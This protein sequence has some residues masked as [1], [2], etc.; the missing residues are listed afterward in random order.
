MEDN[1][2]RKRI[3]RLSQGR[4][5]DPVPKVVL[6]CSELTMN[7]IW[8]HEKTGSFSVKSTNGVTLN[9]AVY[10]SSPYVIIKNSVISGT[11]VSV[12]F[13]LT[14]TIFYPGDLLTGEFVIVLNRFET[15]LP[16]KFSFSK[17]K[18]S[19]K[20]RDICNMKDF[21]ML[22][23]DDIQSAMNLFYRSDF[24]E[25]ME[26]ADTNL[27]LIYRGYK[28][29]IP[30]QIN[31][32]NF[33]SD[34]GLKDPVRITAGCREKKFIGMEVDTAGSITLLKNT[35]GYLSVKIS[36]DSSFIEL[37]KTHIR[38]ND[39]L[40]RECHIGFVIKRDALHCGL[41]YGTIT[42]T[43]DR[44]KFDFLIT[45]SPDTEKEMDRRR[46]NLAAGYLI[47]GAC[48]S[49]ISMRLGISSPV[50]FLRDLRDAITAVTAK[51]RDEA[52]LENGFLSYKPSHWYALFNVYGLIMANE[53]RDALSAIEILR[54]SI[55]DRKSP[56]WAFLLYLLILMGIDKDDTEKLTVEIEKIFQ[57]S[58]EDP[59]LFLILLSVRNEYRA[60]KSLKLK[61]IRQWVM[62]GY[63]SPFF[64]LEA[65]LVA[66]DNPNLL[67][68]INDPF[69]R[70]ILHF[71]YKKKVFSDSI[72]KRIID[73]MASDPAFRPDTL[74]ILINTYNEKNSDELLTEIVRYMIRGKRKEPLDARW[75]LLAIEKNLPVAGIYEFYMECLPDDSS[76]ALPE[77]VLMYFRYPGTLSYEKQAFLYSSVVANKNENGKIYEEYRRDSD[78]FAISSAMEHT[79]NE[80]TLILYHDL[81]RRNIWPERE[82]GFRQDILFTRRVHVFLK[83]AVRLV[84]YQNA[85]SSPEMV[86]VI[87]G[88]S[89]VRIFDRNYR[90]FIEDGRGVRYSSRDLYDTDRV[91]ND[92]SSDDYSDDFCRIK[93]YLSHSDTGD[94]ILD[95]PEIAKI[96]LSSDFIRPGFL[97]ESLRKIMINEDKNSNEYLGT[98]LWNH[99]KEHMPDP[100]MRRICLLFG[101][102]HG[103]FDDA[104]KFMMRQ[105]VYKIPAKEE[106]NLL[107]NETE[108]E[109]EKAADFI[110]KSSANLMFSGFYTDET[111]ELLK[112]KYISSA[113]NMSRF[114]LTAYQS[115]IN[116]FELAEK[117][118]ILIL[119]T[120]NSVPY[121]REAFQVYT[122]REPGPDKMLTE[123]FLTYFSHEYIHGKVT[124]DPYFFSYLFRLVRAG[125]E[126]NESIPV[127]LMKYLCESDSLSDEENDILKELMENFLSRKIYFDFFMKAPEKI[128][129]KYKIYD[130]TIISIKDLPGQDI[131]I[132]Y[133][134]DGSVRT[135]RMKEMYSGIYVKWFVLFSDEEMT[136]EIMKENEPGNVMKSG[137]LL[138]RRSEKEN[139]YG[140][141]NEIL[142]KEAGPSDKNGLRDIEKY[143]FLDALTA[144]VFK[145]L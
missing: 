69:V 8:N 57:M 128:Q 31:F 89:Y 43:S 11:D 91:I 105:Y 74:S 13:S 113:R 25:F 117:T 52:E 71:A 139:R 68:D 109:D 81:M 63:N 28:N 135:S 120:D 124:P 1:A 48:S 84:V 62:N 27:S 19:A 24:A 40:G 108:T 142:L 143:A 97:N 59:R 121:P 72:Y 60:D 116:I 45:A 29:A 88:M 98:Y 61:A 4:Q 66:A 125:Y 111:L 104:L 35:W 47:H 79:V 145:P 132:R 44:N 131:I 137:S 12:S 65:Y 80:D 15:T 49:Y 134:E 99:R 141:L 94:N 51:E 53:R 32:E 39:F 17:S 38:E 36:T 122:G 133:K 76:M 112:N 110:I 56:E 115:N 3:R 86:P 138:C 20:N 21:L 78:A 75:Y 140:R 9:G 123:A 18:I 50:E 37:E 83:S 30:S 41:N 5:D 114:F 73:L 106:L 129:Y 107:S 87:N 34:A 33:L 16:F 90:I 82:M 2:V 144:K 26:S 127:A 85:V 92:I 100:E 70:K 126:N 10:S 55:T 42:V 54:R 7:F 14:D 103:F 102:R 67:T 93:T 64:I 6:S 130:R 136:Y 22:S 119:Y 95:D 101:I 46:K 58:P 96:I 118:I 23:E 77:K